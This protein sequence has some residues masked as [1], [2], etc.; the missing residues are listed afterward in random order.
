MS[1]TQKPGQIVVSVGSD[2]M[3]LI[4]FKEA[5]EVVFRHLPRFDNRQTALS[6]PRRLSTYCHISNGPVQ[7]ICLAFKETN[8]KS[9][10]LVATIADSLL[11]PS[12]CLLL[13]SKSPC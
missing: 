5:E 7:Y 6:S 9:A 10:K 2:V 11:S 8:D 4:T 3:R 1:P 13:A 12:L